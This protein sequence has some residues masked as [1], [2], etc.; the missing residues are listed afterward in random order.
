MVNTQSPPAAT[1]GFFSVL[2]AVLAAP[3]AERSGDLAEFVHERSWLH[4][5]A[6]WMKRSGVERPTHR[7]VIRVLVRDIAR[8]DDLLN[9]QVNAILHQRDFQRFEASW[10]GLQYLVAQA[11]EAEN[12]KVRVLHL[13]WRELVRDQERAIEFDQSQLFRKVYSEEFGTPGGEPYGILLAD[14]EVRHRPGPDH[15]TD[16]LA[17]LAGAAGVAAASFAPLIIAADPPLLDLEAFTELERSHNLQQ[18]M[19][20]ADYIKWHSLRHSDDSRFLGI[21][22]PRVLMRAPYDQRRGRAD[23]FRFREDV[24]GPDRSKYLWGTAVY[25]FGAVAVQAFAD[26]GWFA[27]LRGVRPGFRGQGLASGLA[28]HAFT[29][30][31]DGV[32]VKSS[33]DVALTEPRE[34]ELT[35]LGFIPLCHCPGT[36]HSAFFSNMSMQRPANYD[37]DAAAIN[38]RMSAMI[39]YILCVGRFAHYL[40]VMARDRV[41]SFTDPST[42]EDYLQKWLMSYSTANSEMDESMRAKY[43]LREA[44]VQVREA[45]GKPGIFQCIMHLCPHSQLDQVLAAVRLSTELNPTRR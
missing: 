14:Y 20:K 27:E 19:A 4:A 18:A 1:G 39:Q 6:W 31:R 45:A 15:P 40:K 42:L 25:A 38:A 36:E 34:K 33:T 11:S 3:A 9:A 23:K 26:S 16:D 21:V 41:G 8:L 5:L 2:D 37:R 28:L 29:T 43:P 7:D 22:L 30:D 32:A 17:A 12:V 13:T 10:R 44:Q 35:E 24:G